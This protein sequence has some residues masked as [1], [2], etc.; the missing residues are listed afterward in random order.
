MTFRVGPVP[1]DVARTWLANSTRIVGAVRARPDLVPFIL[2]VPLLDLCDAYLRFWIDHA[3]G[4]E[5][6]DWQA[7]VDVSHVEALA[8]QWITIAALT[9]EQLHAL[10]VDWAP[11]WTA[12][13]YDA[14]LEATVT[15]LASDSAGRALASRLTA[16]PPG[17]RG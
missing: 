3:E 16:Q 4:A 17:S 2:D 12:P 10:G 11:S 8:M 6:F 14:L 13:F 5:T 15:A 1:G 7:D 9:D